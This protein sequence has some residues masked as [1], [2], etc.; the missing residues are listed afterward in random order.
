MLGESLDVRLCKRCKYGATCCVLI[1]LHLPAHC[2]PVVSHHHHLLDVFLL[3]SAPQTLPLPSVVQFIG[4][5]I[6]NFGR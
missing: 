6:A 5:F 2:L 4:S 1:P 3:A